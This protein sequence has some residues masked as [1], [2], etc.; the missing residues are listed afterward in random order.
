MD[1]HSELVVAATDADAEAPV[2]GRLPAVEQL[3]DERRSEFR[4]YLEDPE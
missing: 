1:D 4:S 3:P 2:T